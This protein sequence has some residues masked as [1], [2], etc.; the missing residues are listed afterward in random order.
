[1]TAPHAFLLAW[2]ALALLFTAVWA[3]QLRTGNASIID[4]WWA[5][6]LG[7]IGVFYAWASPGDLA[8]RLLAG[9]MLAVWG[10]R[11]GTYIHRRGQGQ[12]EDGRYTRLREEHGAPA[13][14]WM[15]GFFLLQ[16][17]FSMLLSLG[18]LVAM[19]R[20]D[21]PHA[22]LLVL[23]VVIWIVAVIGEAVADHQLA[24]FKRDPAHRGQ[25]CRAGLWRYSR[26]PN[27][28]FECLHWAAY[29]PLALGAAWGWLALLPPAVMAFLLLKLS[30]LPVTEAQA[31]RT[32][33]GYAEYIRTT[34]ALIPWPP[35]APAALAETKTL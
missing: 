7:G 6:S 19:G 11:L 31:A 14:G 9:T 30:G 18:P 35:R 25:V 5:W 32:R 10:L 16:T 1:M 8:T 22:A 27:Y 21:R 34:S 23:A 28:F 24:A 26:H 33:P 4:A 15:L 13:N 20:M 17:V 12:P 29:V 2:L 3:A